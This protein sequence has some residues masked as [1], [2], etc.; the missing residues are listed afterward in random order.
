[1]GQELTSRCDA[2]VVDLTVCL[3]GSSTPATPDQ[4]RRIDE[5]AADVE[6][7]RR[8]NERLGQ[9]TAKLRVQLQVLLDPD[10]FKDPNV[11]EE[12]V[13]LAP[14][15]ILNEEMLQLKRVLWDLQ[16]ENAL[17]KEERSHVPN[18]SISHSSRK[19][20][21]G[22]VTLAEYRDM[23]NQVVDLRKAY[24]AAVAQTE[25]LRARKASREGS[26]TH[27]H[28]AANLFIG[29]RRSASAERSASFESPTGIYGRWL[30]MRSGSPHDDLASSRDGY[31]PVSRMTSR[32]SGDDGLSRLSIEGIFVPGGSSPRGGTRSA[33]QSLSFSALPGDR[34]AGQSLS[35][36]SAPGD[37][38]L[39]MQALQHENDQL[40]KKIRALALQ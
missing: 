35:F 27:A 8:E 19:S 16:R 9:Q 28:R 31:Q 21:K 29:R 7:A 32:D 24:E 12:G 2:A 15:P 26:P 20:N 11:I 17:I 30:N 33:G 37:L 38:R 10:K 14:D 1:M 40:R 36:S 25:R 39:R 18:T 5:L 6:E 23:Q 34:S 22:T 13:P 4:S 3:S